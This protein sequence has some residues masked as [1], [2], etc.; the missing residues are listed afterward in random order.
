[1]TSSRWLKETGKKRVSKATSA[2]HGTL[3]DFSIVIPAYNEVDELP[4]TLKAV[5]RALGMQSA[6]GEVIVVDNNSTDNTAEVACQCG[7]DRVVFEP[8]NQIARARNTGGRKARGA[9]LIFVDADTRISGE[10]LAESLR[11]LESGDVGGGAVI[12]FEGEISR[13]GRFAIGLW[14]RISRLTKIAAGSFIFCRK[15]AF[16]AVGGFDETLYAGEELRFSRRLKSWGRP[17]GQAFRIITDC[18]AETSAR[19]LE[20]YSGLKILGWMS[21]M[22]LF[23]FAVRWRRLCGFWY[24]RPG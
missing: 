12:R 16:E 21:F 24:R 8:V 23:P 19:K 2:V 11:R 20:W 7:A 5:R 17:R 10:L 1:M 22:M 14:E 9:Q 6:R 3:P 4:A 13:V 18:P 15:E